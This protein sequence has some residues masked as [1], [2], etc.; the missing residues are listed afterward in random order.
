MTYLIDAWLERP[1]PSLRVLNRDS[2]EV[3]MEL[4]ASELQQLQEQGDL[5]LS[6]L[7]T[8]EPQGIKEMLRTLFLFYYARALRA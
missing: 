6:C 8:S 7:S 5:D 3:C 1:Q 4:G 2:G